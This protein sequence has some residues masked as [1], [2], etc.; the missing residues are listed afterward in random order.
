MSAV[1]AWSDP[2]VVDW[3]EPNGVV[4][5][6]IAEF[7]NTW[8]SFPM[9][10]LGFYGAW[11]SWRAGDDARFA[12]GFAGLGV[13]G[14]GSAAFHGT[15]LRGPQALDEL[16]MVW[17]GLVGVW[18]VLARAAPAG[19][20]GWVAWV[21]LA[22]AVGFTVLY[23]TAPAYFAIFLA[24]YAVLV[25]WMTLASIRWSRAPE[26]DPEAPRLL[27]GAGTGY[28]GALTCFWLPEHVLL[29]C[30]HPMQALPLHGLWHLAAGYGTWL[31]F[32]FARLDRAV[33]TA[34]PLDWHGWW[35]PGSEGRRPSG[36]R[37]V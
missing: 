10:A 12:L 22:Y 5:P 23:A 31:W 27:L 7:H 18:M 28:L 34:R 25:A 16:P 37:A 29:P 19:R 35:V 32:H 17:L 2:S 26:A 24:T 15:L 8:T 13:V 30:D 3:C 36:D 9:A 33:A 6:W 4:V 20:L 1:F 11:R 21:F 14:L